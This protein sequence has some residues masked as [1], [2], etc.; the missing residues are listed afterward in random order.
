[1]SSKEQKLV[2]LAFGLVL[3]I[4]AKKHVD[5]FKNKSNEDKAEWVADQ[6]RKCGFDTS[7]CGSSWGVL[8]GNVNSEYINPKLDVIKCSICGNSFATTY[9]ITGD[10]INCA[11]CGAEAHGTYDEG[12]NYMLE[13]Y[14]GKD[15]S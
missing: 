14:E 3:T 13:W 4:T 9:P 10:S 6:L 12:G 5:V 2:D 11:H 7:P 15:W 8:K 1:M